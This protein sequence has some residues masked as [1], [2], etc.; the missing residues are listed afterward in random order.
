[1]FFDAACM[2]VPPITVFTDAGSFF[3]STGAVSLTGP[4]PDLGGITTPTPVTLGNATLTAPNDMFIGPGWSTLFPGP[5]SHAIALSGLEHLNVSL[6]NGPA[7]AFG[8]YFHEP[9]GSCGGPVCM[10]STFTID[11]Y[12]GGGFVDS[13][14]FSPADDQLVFHGLA[15]VPGPFDEVRFTEIVGTND[16]EFYGEMYAAPAP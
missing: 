3:D 13:I 6:N 9:T 2:P 16:N 12:L 14:N 8:F 4:I 5:G 11:F 1:M 7:T 15:V 10:D